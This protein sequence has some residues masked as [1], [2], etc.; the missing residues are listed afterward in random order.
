MKN[1]AHAMAPTKTAQARVLERGDSISSNDPV[2]MTSGLQSPHEFADSRSRPV[3][4]HELSVVVATLDERENVRELISRLDI[5]LKGVR[6]EAIFVD[7]DS[8]DGTA[9]VLREV[10]AHDPRVRC[11]RRIG[12]KGLSSACIEGILSSSAPYVAVMD[13]DLQHD[14][15]LL[16]L[17]LGALKSGDTDL[18]IASRYMKGGGVGDWPADRVGLSTLATRISKGFL[19]IDVSDPMSGFFAMRRHL[20][21]AH[22]KSLSGLGFKLLLDFLSSAP[23]SLRVREFPYRFGTRRAGH[24]KMSAKVAWQ[25]LFML[26]DKQVGRVVPARF[27]VFGLVGLL[28][29][30]VHYAVLIAALQAV[31]LDFYKAQAFATAAAMVFNYSLNNELTHADRA[32]RGWQWLNG[33]WSFVLV[34]GVGAL[35]NVGVASFL[36]SKDSGWHWAAAAGIM[37]GAVW[38]YAV[39]AR[40]TWK[41][42]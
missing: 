16:P 39:S 31:L 42:N 10:A 14:E 11:I 30:A 20:F 19:H 5:A 41:L 34:C 13:A 2:A 35:A 6:W 15:S 36:F 26:L 37:V 24:S 4:V 3:A 32:F 27:I 28:G 29:V 23:T 33:L 7:D 25:F 38:N 40:Y 9:D 17:M 18:A 21:E 1:W 8:S 12:R 22:A